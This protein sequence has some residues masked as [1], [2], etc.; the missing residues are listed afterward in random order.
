ML[1]IVRCVLLVVCVPVC[2]RLYVV[3]RLLSGACCLL[4]VVSFVDCCLLCVVCGFLFV[5]CFV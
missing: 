3:C 4:V 1:F 2:F 5:A